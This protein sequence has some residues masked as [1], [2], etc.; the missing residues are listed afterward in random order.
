MTGAAGS[1]DVVQPTPAALEQAAQWFALLRSGEATS[2]D[3]AAWQAWRDGADTHRAA[4]SQVEQVG[5]LFQPIQSTTRPRDA[6][7]AYRAA[8]TQAARRRFVLGV[9]A[10]AGAGWVGAAAWRQAWLPAS[11]LAWS[12]DHRAAIGEVRDILLA[13]GTRIWLGTASAFNE[14]YTPALRRLDL[15]AG[16]M[17]ISTAADACRPFVV[18]TLHGRLRALGTRFIVQRQAAWTRIAVYEGAVQAR[19]ASGVAVVIPAGW[20]AEMA[21]DGVSD[22]QRADPAAESAVR[23]LYVVQD[24]PL[25]EVLRELGRYR[26]G[27][28]AVAPEVAGLPVFGSFPMTDPDR[29]LGMLEGVMPIR[30][31]RFLPWWVSVGPR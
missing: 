15:L 22:L 29:V 11:V 8:T 1:G 19:S 25:G 21:R 18:D 6:V 16:E 5:R 27:H 24:V 28:L 20:Q 7:G 10:L 23:G 13:D 2:A 31:R 26:T 30:V 9:A 12:A 3:R 17:L 4:W 14:D